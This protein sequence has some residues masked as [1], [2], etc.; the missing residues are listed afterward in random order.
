MDSFC[1]KTDQILERQNLKENSFC[2]TEQRFQEQ[3][4]EKLTPIG[5]PN[6]Q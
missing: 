3:M 1:S 5:Q 2:L 4:F 6:Q